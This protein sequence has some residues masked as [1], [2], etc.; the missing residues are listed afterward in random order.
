M[1]KNHLKQIVS[2]IIVLLFTLSL[3]FVS[4]PVQSIADSK[5]PLSGNGVTAYFFVFT[6]PENVSADSYNSYWLCDYA[7]QGLITE[8]TKIYNDTSKVP[9]Y[10][11]Y[12]P[13]CTAKYGED[14]YIE[15]NT[16]GYYWSYSFVVGVLKQQE[17]VEKDESAA[18]I[19][20]EATE[21]VT[22]VEEATPSEEPEE[23]EQVEEPEPVIEVVE[24]PEEP[25]P[26]EP[27]EIED[28]M[29]PE[30]ITN[31]VTVTL[32][33]QKILNA[34]K[35]DYSKN[36]VLKWDKFR[37]G[38]KDTYD[39]SIPINYLDDPVYTSMLLPSESRSDS[40]INGWLDNG[41]ITGYIDGRCSAIP[42]GNFPL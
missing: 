35:S 3:F 22:D 41:H 7:G 21:E 8:K 4:P 2:S 32:D 15:W 30:T 1:T 5:V 9:D 42:S 12:A 16:I 27:E 31:P 20:E 24:G 6:D 29:V 13:D 39:G 26:E 40:M 36:T 11:V 33:R 18:I 37:V 38:S 34:K 17:T 14:T 10:I 25:V 23:T 28:D 19:D